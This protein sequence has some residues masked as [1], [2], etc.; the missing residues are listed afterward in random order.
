MAHSM[1]IRRRAVDA[2]LSGA[3]SYEFVSDLLQVG[4][5]S[6]KR[7]VSR[8]RNTGNIDR[9]PHGGGVDPIIDE[10]GLK[11]L[12]AELKV[13]N[14]LTLGDLCT[15]LCRRFR[16]TVS[17]ATMGRAV[18][19]RLQWPRKKRRTGRRSETNPKRRR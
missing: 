3:G 6:L 19:E 5:A 13:K 14:D 15:R 2:Y 10:D 8:K 1:E 18:R 7:W 12:E 16:E 4:S 9:A 17:P 11:W